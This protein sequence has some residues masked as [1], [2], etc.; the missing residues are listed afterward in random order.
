MSCDNRW[1]AL[2]LVDAC[3]A[4]S[5]W[6]DSGW[7]DSGWV[8]SGWVDSGWVD[9]GWVDSGWVDSG[10]SGSGS[11]SVLPTKAAARQLSFNDQQCWLAVPRSSRCRTYEQWQAQTALGALN[12]DHVHRI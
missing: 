6:A 4:D 1:C 11:P 2:S 9:L 12:L 5:G 7:A 8:D 10:R 3:W